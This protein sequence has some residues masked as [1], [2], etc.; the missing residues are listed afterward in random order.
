M[1]N[2]VSEI[3][4]TNKCYKCG[5][6]KSICPF[7][8]VSFK[9]NKKTGFYDF[10]IS[11]SL[12]KNCGKCLALCPG[13]NPINKTGSPVGKNK[14]IVLAHSK[15]ENIRKAATS[16]GV[17]NSLLRYLIKNN[18]IDFA[19]VVKE[20]NK[21]IFDST[22]VK[23]TKDNIEKLSSAPRDF[24]SRYVGVPVLAYLNADEIKNE[25]IAVVGT[26]CQIKA[27]ES[28]NNIFKIGIACSGMIS[29]NATKVIK[30]KYANNKYHIFYRGNG[31]PGYNSLIL[32]NDVK[33][34]PH[35]KSDFEKLFSSQIFKNPACY[36]CNDQFATCADISL[37][38]F[39]NK[40]EMKNEKTGNSAVIIRNDKAEKI[41]NGAINLN[42]IETVKIISEEDAVKTQ[43]FP[44]E[45]KE[46]KI[47]KKFPLN[48]FLKII[49]KINSSGFY[50]KLSVNQMI[51]IS[52]IFTKVFNLTKRIHK[53]K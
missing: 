16:G 17:V 11:Q 1:E 32:N 27:I 10:N 51:I 22:A 37:F 12:C 43:G 38:D 34:T 46:N 24:A 8:A 39:W 2:S 49:N 14:K 28:F 30:Q 19:L 6:C 33:E 45:F 53:L 42:Y 44:L 47:A 26:P 40:D 36:N 13:A 21:N 52:K 25:K 7:G 50:K 41:F 29:Y 3:I 20:D 18:I 35:S 31:W 4:K 9:E 48:I 23:L 5:M 15:D